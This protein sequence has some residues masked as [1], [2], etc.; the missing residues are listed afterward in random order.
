MA[1]RAPGIRLDIER[2]VIDGLALADRAR[3]ERA[4]TDECAAGLG[5]AQFENAAIRS[6]R[7]DIALAQ[8]ASPEA[9]GRVVARGIVRLVRQP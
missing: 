7:I 4:F 9:I 1:V 6:G 3:F 2:I 8:D 5:V